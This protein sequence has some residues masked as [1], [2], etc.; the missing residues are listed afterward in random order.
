MFSTKVPQWAES[1]LCARVS[2]FIC[3]WCV[4][5]SASS[6]V[7]PFRHLSEWRQTSETFRAAL[8]TFA[9]LLR[10]CR[11][12]SVRDNHPA[13][14]SLPLIP[15]TCI[16]GFSEHADP[17]QPSPPAPTL[18]VVAKQDDS[19]SCQVFNGY[20]SRGSGTLLGMF[21]AHSAEDTCTHTCLGITWIIRAVAQLR[22]ML[23]RRGSR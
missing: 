16:P 3:T 13:S 19:R 5:T 21:L 11:H 20:L 1:G 23:P 15:F 4:V 6:P 7:N 22:D 8:H 10:E 9:K 18:E 12:N 17:I 14:V 2:P